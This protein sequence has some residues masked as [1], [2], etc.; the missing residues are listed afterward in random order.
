LQPGNHEPAHSP[1]Y[2]LGQTNGTLTIIPA[3]STSGADLDGFSRRV[4]AANGWNVAQRTKSYPP[5]EHVI[6]I[7]KE[8]RTYD[9]IFG[10]AGQSGDGHAADGDPSL[11]IFGGGDAAK[12]P[13][14]TG[15]NITP[16]Q[17]A[18]ALRFGLFDR[19]FVNA[20][21]S[22]EGHNWSTAAFSSDYVDKTYRW[23]R[24]WDGVC[25]CHPPRLLAPTR[26]PPADAR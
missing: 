8:N 13:V 1:D 11:A 9:Q 10:D 12:L 6:Y 19:F 25:G 3:G 22:P 14:G 21:S 20:A 18:L 4:A 16:N 17:R 5:F 7:I 26:G 2:T 24:S 23:Q 15:Q